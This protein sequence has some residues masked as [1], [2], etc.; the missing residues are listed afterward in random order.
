MPKL[1]AVR[2]KEEAQQVPATEPLEIILAPEGAEP[3]PEPDDKKA[4][5]EPAVKAKA[6][7]PEP[8]ADAVTALKDQLEKAQK[9]E[10]LAQEAVRAAQQQAADATRERDDIRVRSAQHQQQA[11]DARYTAVVNALGAAVAESEAAQQAWEAAD[12]AGDSKAKGEAQR[13]LARAEANVARYEDAKEDLDTRRADAKANPPPPPRQQQQDPVEQAI[14]SMPQGAQQ[15]L[16]SHPEFITDARK[17]AKLQA[18]HWDVLDEGHSQFSTAYFQSLE[19]HLGLRQKANPDQEPPAPPARRTSVPS[20]PPSRDVPSS[21]TGRA[22]PSRV[23]LTAEEREF[24]RMSGIDEVTYAKG[25]LE[26]ARRKGTGMYQE[27]G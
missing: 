21:T 11:E 27:R 16:R 1:R 4:P 6:P 22:T 25:K 2:T 9:A 5:P 26:L 12:I 13:R 7:E 8:E 17:N 15:W 14:A 23:E 20:A 3:P 24:A 18:L 10:Q 19:E